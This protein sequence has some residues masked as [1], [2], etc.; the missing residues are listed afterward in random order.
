MDNAGKLFTKSKSSAVRLLVFTTIIVSTGTSARPYIVGA[1]I[2]WVLE[3]ESRGATYWDDGEQKDIFELLKEYGLN[4][5]RIRT[6]VD[7][8]APGGYASRGSECWCD[9]EHTVEIGKRIKDA[10][11]GFL[12]DFHMSDTWASIGEQHVPSAWANDN[13][14]QMRQHAY[15]Y[16]KLNIQTLIDSGARPD[17]VQVG[18]EINS[19]MSG[20]S[21]SNP[22]RFA[23]L[24]NAGVKGVRDV[25]STIKIVMQHGRPRPDGD[26]MS[27]YN[28][29]KD[30]VD[31]DFIGGSTYG[32][33]NNGN[34]WREMFGNVVRDGTPVMSLEYTAN[35]TALINTVMNEL[36]NRMGLGT[37]AWE[38]IR[39]D[40][41]MFDRDGNKYTPNARLDELASFAR[42]FDATLPGFVQ[43]DPVPVEHGRR[44]EL[45][46]LQYNPSTFAVNIGSADKEFSLDLFLI[47]GS[48]VFSRVFRAGNGECSVT[49]PLY[50]MKN[51][52]YLLKISAKDHAEIRQITIL[53]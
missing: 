25:D 38:P 33:T 36:P 35:R 13:D 29:I 44:N 10:D 1:D 28:A 32:T 47:D 31:Y 49:L 34:D 6:F 18:N 51:G 45:R 41:P 40:K 39:Y 4:F 48:K 17:M 27:W 7:P 8:C 11:M 52:T 26:F 43:T 46:E 3:D 15:E 37:F 21:I 2:S 22:D 42:K 30:R 50:R 19:K 16:T 20:V 9:L 23:A 12:L 5:I 14:E 53:K 24:I